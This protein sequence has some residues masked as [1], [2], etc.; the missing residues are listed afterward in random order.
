MPFVSL[1]RALR[2][3]YTAVQY[4]TDLC[5]FKMQK[6]GFVCMLV[7]LKKILACR[8]ARLIQVCDI[9]LFIHHRC[10]CG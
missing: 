9:H 6:S 10:C 1:H 3:K 5:V 4:N 7:I 2:S 8:I